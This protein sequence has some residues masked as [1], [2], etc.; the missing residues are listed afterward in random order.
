[1]ISLSLA[2]VFS[3]NVG[4]RPSSKVK[5]ALGLCFIINMPGVPLAICPT[6]R[7]VNRLIESNSASGSTNC[8][9]SIGPRTSRIAT[10]TSPI[11][12]ARLVLPTNARPNRCKKNTSSDLARIAASTS[13]LLNSDPRRRLYLPVFPASVPTG[14]READGKAA[15]LL[16]R[17][18][19]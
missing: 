5:T 2:D 1:M 10:K 6:E 16:R 18:A 19:T 17:K 3:A 8:R 13:H 7:T 9:A 11:Q 4:C 14:C 12:I 15:F